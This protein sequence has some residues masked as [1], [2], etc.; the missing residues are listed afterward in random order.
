MARCGL[1]VLL[2]F[3]GVVGGAAGASLAG[4]PHVLRLV[5]HAWGGGWATGLRSQSVS[6]GGRAGL[7][8]IW[9]T[10]GGGERRCMSGIGGRVVSRVKF[11]LM[12]PG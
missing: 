5:G 6:I 9:G 2:G 3:R 10:E 1:R 12:D 7:E 4:T 11:G 8:G